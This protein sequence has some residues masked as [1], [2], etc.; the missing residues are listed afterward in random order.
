MSIIN[1]IN[2]KKSDQKFNDGRKLLESTIKGN[3]TREQIKKDLDT[4][5][6]SFNNKDIS[7]GIACRYHNVAKWSPALF[8]ASNTHMMLWDGSDS[9]ETAEAYRNDTI[10]TIHVFVLENKNQVEHTHQ[11]PNLGT[12]K[13]VGIKYLFPN[14]K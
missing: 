11:K 9:P 10:D 14:I 5:A 8:R 3:F 7:L 12:K 2:F 6:K 4:L 1:K 13:Q